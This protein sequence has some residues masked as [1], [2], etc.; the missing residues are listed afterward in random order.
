MTALQNNRD[1]GL[2]AKV[3]KSNN[4]K[5]CVCVCVCV[6]VAIGLIWEYHD[7]QKIIVLK[8]KEEKNGSVS[9]FSKV[10]T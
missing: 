2:N 4:S 10:S 7:G 9:L 6:C 3:C 8:D 1:A 5:G